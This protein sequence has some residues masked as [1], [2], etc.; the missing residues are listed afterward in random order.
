MALLTLAHKLL[1]TGPTAMTGCVKYGDLRL[2][3]T[4]MRQC[5]LEFKDDRFFVES[6]RAEVHKLV[7]HCGLSTRSRILD[8]GCGPGR[9]PIGILDVLETVR[10]Y[11]GIDVVSDCIEWGRRWIAAD[12]PEFRFTH[13]NVYNERYNPKGSRRL[14]DRFGF[15]FPDG[16]FDMIYLYSVFSHMQIE[17]IRVYLRELRRVLAPTGRIFLTAYLE[18]GVPDISINPAG[19]RECTQTP[20]HRV[21][22]NKNFFDSLLAE[23]GLT[24]IRF[25]HNAEHDGQSGIYLAHDDGEPV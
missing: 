16:H 3:P 1:G 17:D 13:R 22:L 24:E 5:S 25:D 6:A 14:D 7:E 18:F 8:I 11:E 23:N 4:P 12:H 15:D 2:P 9:L 20:L 10:G 19:Y 21:R